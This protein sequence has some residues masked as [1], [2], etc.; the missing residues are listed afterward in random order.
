MEP[1]LLVPGEQ[2]QP[3]GIA[4]L[5]DE[6]MTLPDFKTI[7][8]N[9]IKNIALNKIG[10]KIGLESLGSTMLGTSINPLIGISALVG[11][12]KVISSYLQD[13]R[14]QKQLIAA[15]NKN[16]IQQIQQRLDNQNSSGGDRGRGDRPG[17]ANQ[18]AP[19]TSPR[20]GFDSSER[21]AALHG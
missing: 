9:V 8:S 7:G 5:V 3:S 14:M 20:G 6:G 15:Q 11:K 18:S 16:Q 10:E 2:L 19:S 21:G 13:K 12:R 1:D 4:P 17:G